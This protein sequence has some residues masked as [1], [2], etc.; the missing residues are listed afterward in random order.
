MAP[1]GRAA[2]VLAQRAG[3]LATT[4]HKRIYFTATDP[5]GSVKMQLAP[6]K[7]SNVVFIIDEASMIADYSMQ[8][9]GSVGRNL[10]EDIFEYENSDMVE[11]ELENGQIIKCTP[12]HEFLIDENWE[13]P[14]SWIRADELKTGD[15]ILSK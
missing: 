10:L 1:T 11:I 14:E 12:N 7:S 15:F 3:T 4:I 8:N 2:K 6:N 13:N 5:N 9:D